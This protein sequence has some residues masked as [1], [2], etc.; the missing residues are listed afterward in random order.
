MRFLSVVLLLSAVTLFSCQNESYEAVDEELIANLKSVSPTGRID[1]FMMPSSDDYDNI[2]Q[3]PK[4]PLTSVKIMLGQQLFH[5]TGIGLGAQMEEGMATYSCASCHNA[6]AGFQAGLQQGIGDGGLGF[7][8]R[9]EARLANPN[10]HNAVDVQPIKTPAA[11][12]TAYQK[13]ML[14]NGQ[15]GATGENVNTEDRWTQGSPLETN[16]LGYEGVETQAIAGLSV[17]R[18]K[19]D[20]NIVEEIMCK[21]KFDKAFP[22]FPEEKRYSTETAGL[23]IAAY[24]RTLLAN[25]SRFQKWLR[26][27]VELTWAER[28]GAE[29]F[30]GKGA[31]VDCHTGP[32]LNAMEFHALGMNNLD[33]LSNVIIPKV[34]EAANA[35]LGRGGFTGKAEDNYK[36]KVPQL[37]NLASNSFYGHGSSFTSIEDIV[38]YKN[39]GI[40]ENK[41][42]NTTSIADEFRP[43][44]LTEE[45]IKNLTLFLSFTLYDSELERYKPTELRSH[46][47]FPNADEQSKK[48][49]G[50]D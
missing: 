21:E 5:E 16:T 3:D 10:Y 22:D 6:D 49:V 14:W 18:M 20:K 41:N 28:K 19:I 31:C 11:L 46:N 25:Q 29:V 9:G 47:C 38:R 24:E 37:Y 32:T 17:H 2:P 1:Y 35:N 8:S 12:N 39:K 50:C 43:L 23:A 36:F 42:V 4:N 40:P 48:D 13:N 34:E 7:G 33:D 44:H 30:F 26:N 45:E 15:F 27:E